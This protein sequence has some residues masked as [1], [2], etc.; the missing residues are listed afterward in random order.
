[1]GRRENVAVLKQVAA[2]IHISPLGGEKILQALSHPGS[3]CVVRSG[4][5]ILQTPVTRPD[6]TGV[7]VSLLLHGGSLEGAGR[8]SIVTANAC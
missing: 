8:N 3:F 5:F 7:S 6:Q 2:I 4:A 1:M